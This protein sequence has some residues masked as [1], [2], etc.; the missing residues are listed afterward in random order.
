MSKP[1]IMV[2]DDEVDVA[3]AIANTIRDTNKYEV[4]VANSGQEAL[5]Q[6][7]KHKIMFGLGGNKVRLV[8]LDIKMPEMD[9]LSLLEKIRKD[10][11]PDI[12]VSMLTAWEDAEKWERATAGFVINYIRKPFKANELIKT[13]D[14]FFEDDESEMV[15]KTMEK[16]LQ[17]KE[18]FK[19]GK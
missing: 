14:D 8:L 18:E 1:L 2:V 3:N 17:K 13:L 16:H 9:G 5:S 4:I 12:G 10:F 6:L 15:I 11:G 7:A 19:R